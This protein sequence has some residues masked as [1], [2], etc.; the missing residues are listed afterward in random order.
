MD[1]LPAPAFGHRQFLDGE[2]FVSVGALPAALGASIAFDDLWAMR[3][4]RPTL[5]LHGRP[6]EAP[7][8]QQ[9]YGRA[10]RFSGRVSEALEVPVLLRPLLDWAHATIDGRLNGLLVN[11][12]AEPGDQIDPARTSS[13][14]DYIGPHRDSRNGLVDD[15]SIVTISFGGTR[16]FRLRSHGD[17]RVA[18]DIPVLAGTVVMLPYATNL[19]YTH[20]VPRPSSTR[21]ETGRRISV[22][23]RAF[24]R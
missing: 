3:T 13:A 5:V 7:R 4:S 17:R 2:N 9:A 11:W 14:G 18:L 23:L 8:W 6:T 15:A 16:T 21:G 24:A 22:T 12:Y 19:A 1:H 20:E 10:Y